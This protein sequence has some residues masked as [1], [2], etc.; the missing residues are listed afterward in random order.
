[1][2]RATTQLSSLLLLC[3]LGGSG[4]VSRPVVLNRE[5]ATSGWHL[6]KITGG[7]WQ[8][9]LNDQVIQRI[10]LVFHMDNSVMSLA[11]N[12][13]LNVSV[14]LSVCTLAPATESAA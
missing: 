5:P 14:G 4:S 8:T 2:L 3:S 6:S 1:M 13:K 11:L 7:F 10:A 12:H 9:H